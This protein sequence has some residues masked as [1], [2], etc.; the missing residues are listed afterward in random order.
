MQSVTQTLA[1]GTQVIDQIYSVNE[2]PYTDIELPE[3]LNTIGI[4]LYE[5]A[6]D[7]L[8]GC[9]EDE[10]KESKSQVNK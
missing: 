1:D 7:E 2:F 9:V 6:I 3:V 4:N 5:I 10:F 8:V